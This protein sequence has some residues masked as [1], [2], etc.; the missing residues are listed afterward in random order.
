MGYKGVLRSMAAAQ[1]RQEREAKRQQR[2]FERQRKQLEKM[3]LFEQARFEVE[4]FENYIEVITSVQKE[5]GPAWDWEAIQNR[6]APKEPL[7]DWF[8]DRE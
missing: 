7:Q 6:P 1:R 5:C 4:E 3:Q 2:E 8:T